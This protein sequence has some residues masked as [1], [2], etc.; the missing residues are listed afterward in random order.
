MTIPLQWECAR[1]PHGNWNIFKSTIGCFNKIY[2][3][4]T[5]REPPS[6]WTDLSRFRASLRCI[7]I[8]ICFAKNQTPNKLPNIKK[9]LHENNS[10]IPRTII[11]STSIYIYR[12]YSLP[13]PQFFTKNAEHQRQIHGLQAPSS[14]GPVDAKVAHDIQLVDTTWTQWISSQKAWKM[15]EHD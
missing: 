11:Y 5:P 14:V 12:I 9:K 4:Q 13:N 1:T 2:A 15:L 3:T 7:N 6:K 10:K 8:L